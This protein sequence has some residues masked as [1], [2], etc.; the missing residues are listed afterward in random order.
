MI[1]L[2]ITITSIVFLLV[3]TLLYSAAKKPPVS[4]ASFISVFLFCWMLSFI[5][6]VAGLVT[7]IWA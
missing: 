2:K 7:W 4:P 6:V 1:G 5:G 3:F